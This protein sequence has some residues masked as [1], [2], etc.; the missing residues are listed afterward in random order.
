VKVIVSEALLVHRVSY[1]ESDVIATLLTETD[2]KLGVLVRG[3]RKSSRRVGGALEPVHTIEVRLEDRGGDLATLREGRIVRVRGGIVGSLDALDAAGMALR[4]ARH[5]CPVRTREPEAWKTLIALLDAL[6]D[7]AMNA[8][9]PRIE[10]AGAALRLLADVGYA[11]DLERCVRCGKECPEGRP[12][13]IDAARGGLICSA[14]GGARIIL[15]PRVR[16][17]ARAALAG[18]TRQAIASMSASDAETILGL[19]EDAMAAHAGFDR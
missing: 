4:W 11:L 17:V 10:L 19:V 1:G 5:A 2:G 12:A 8:R 15:E 18:E 9:S 16:A 6:D 14:C 13:G 7:A 3:G